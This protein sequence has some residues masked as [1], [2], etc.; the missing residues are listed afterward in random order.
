MQKQKKILI[1]FRLHYHQSQH[2]RVKNLLPITERTCQNHNIMH[3][4]CSV[5]ILLQNQKLTLLYQVERKRSHLA[6]LRKRYEEVT[7]LSK[8]S[9]LLHRE[10]EKLGSV[11][12]ELQISEKFP[13]F[14]GTVLFH[15]SMTLP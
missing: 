8:Q 9:Q 10:K 1:A 2:S 6:A 11:M 5:I 12:G 13:N 7:Y 14:K 4:F 3:T 15:P